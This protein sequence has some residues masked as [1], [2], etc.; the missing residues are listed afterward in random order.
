MRAIVYAAPLTLELQ[1]VPEPR[2]AVGEVLVDVRAVGICGSEL[3][4]FRSQSPVRVQPLAR[5]VEEVVDDLPVG[6]LGAAGRRRGVRP[7]DR[8]VGRPA[9]VLALQ[10]LR[11]PLDLL[12][13]PTFLSR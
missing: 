8:R 13:H 12:G 4:G 11:G 5:P 2:P 1:D 10:L 6:E 3:E 7:R 9:A